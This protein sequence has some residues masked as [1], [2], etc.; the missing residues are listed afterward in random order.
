MLKYGTNIPL[1]PLSL[2]LFPGMML[3]LHI[4]EER[5]KAMITEC[6][7]A[8]KSFGVVLA[9]NKVAQAPNV[10]NLFIDDIYDVGT[11]AQI[12]AV[13]RLADNKM[14][15]IT[16]GQERFLIKSIRAS[17]DDFLIGE[18]D[19][20]PMPADDNASS[21]NNLVQKLRP[22]VKQY[23]DYLADASGEDLSGAT[24]PRDPAALAYLAGMAMQGPLPDKQ[25][26]LAANS[27]SGLIAKTVS[28][29][30]RENQI[31]AYMIR[32]YQAHQRVQR[33]PFVDYSLN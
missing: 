21:I 18:V 2:V 25:Q 16:V 27:L 17:Q 22:M 9:K 24:L 31:M 8:D 32:A 11:T 26:L 33:L 4:F 3:P 1:F 13:E 15:L 23:I 6:L 19:P 29:M 30:D 20:Y 14:N 28:V 7:A 5:Y 10:D 12:T